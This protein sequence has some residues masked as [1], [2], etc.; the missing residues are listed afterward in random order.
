MRIRTYGVVRG[1]MLKH[2]PTRF[3]NLLPAAPLPEIPLLKTA[4]QNPSPEIP[5]LKPLPSI[6]SRNPHPLN[7]CLPPLS[8]ECRISKGLSVGS[9]L[10][11][12]HL[13][14]PDLPRPLKNLRYLPFAC[15]NISLL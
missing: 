11:C 14:A 2:P 10:S 4:F 3:G 5:H 15:R 13:S 6:L 1:V 12:L 8:L 7:P 9:F